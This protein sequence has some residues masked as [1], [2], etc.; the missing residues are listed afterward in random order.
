MSARAAPPAPGDVAGGGKATE[1]D[2]SLVH[3]VLWTSAVKWGS[4]LLTW[5]STL[6]VARVL[7]PEAYGLIG[8]AAI[9][10]TF[11]TLLSEF[12][13]GSAIV[14]LRDLTDDQV[15]QINT[16][17]VLFGVLAVALSFAVAFPLGHLF[18]APQLPPVVMA[19]SAS[20]LLAAFQ[21][22]PSSLLQREMR[23]KK[24]A[25]LEGTQAVVLA[26]S[27]V[28]FALAGF[29]YW[30][31]VIGQLLGAAVLSV[32]LLLARP[33]RFARPRLDSLREA[34]TFSWHVIAARISWYI[35]S[36]A[37]FVVVG[38]VLGKA[39]LGVYSF[40]WTLAS[41][42][43][44]KITSLVIRVTPAIFSAVQSD[45]PALRRY[46]LTLTEGIAL[47]TFPAAFGLVLVAEPFVLTVLG[48][49]WRGTIAPLQL[50]AAYAAVRSLSPLLAQVLTVVGETRF[51]MRCNLLAAVLLPA[52]FYL[53]ARWGTV[54]VAAVWII[55]H[56]T[57]ILS[58]YY[59]RTLRVIGLS[60]THYLDALGPALSGSAGMLL[61]VLLLKQ[62]APSAWP[63]PIQLGVQVTI[64]AIAYAAV[65]L[66]FH[67]ARLRSFRQMLRQVR[68]SSAP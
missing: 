17:S 58:L 6:I 30:T 1:L 64:G 39:A 23:F 57:L 67:G 61:S 32:L 62:I 38:R 44:E 9:Y 40:G 34:M 24:L 50:L 41:V 3:G 46:L 43:V 65:V 21:T 31:L 68:A 29:G 16:L 35:Y 15:G 37:D 12:G 22:V 53:G 51:L 33:Y 63:L 55:V 60:W 8:M 66:G 26:L 7:G 20:F 18:H 19:L 42:P 27:M 48:E 47:V 4:Q 28:G 45:P 54:G 52:G 49:P 10:M 2:R 25:A 14:T 11:V 59:R 13:I 5:A 36:D 56:P